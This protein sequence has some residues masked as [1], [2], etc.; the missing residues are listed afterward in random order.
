LRQA[1][2]FRQA[3]IVSGS[4]RVVGDFGKFNLDSQS[5]ERHADAWQPRELLADRLSSLTSCLSARAR[6]MLRTFTCGKGLET[7]EICRLRWRGGTFVPVLDLS[8]DR[9]AHHMV[10]YRLR[11]F[12][13][14]V[15]PSIRGWARAVDRRAKHGTRNLST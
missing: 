5:L 14:S 9:T 2:F 1:G 4:S 6:R 12:L 8:G 15:I 3:V 13:V 7:F 10:G 11:C